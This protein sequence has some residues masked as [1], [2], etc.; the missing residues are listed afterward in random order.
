MGIS[1][2]TVELLASY[3][4][5]L[6]NFSSIFQQAHIHIVLFKLQH[7]TLCSLRNHILS[8]KCTFVIIAGYF[9]V[10]IQLI[11]TLKK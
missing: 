3:I 11:G 7:W 4:S 2:P 10:S 6:K 5:I 8:R 1:F 9:E